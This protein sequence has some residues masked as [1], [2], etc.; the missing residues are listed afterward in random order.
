MGRIEKGIL[1]LV[2][3]TA[4]R[5]GP[6]RLPAGGEDS[7]HEGQSNPRDRCRRHKS[8]LGTWKDLERPTGPEPLEVKSHL[9]MQSV[10][11]Y[12]PSQDDHIGPAESFIA[13]IPSVV[14]GL[15]LAFSTPA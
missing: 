9:P 14:K 13:G 5:P 2:R 8:L 3:A 15:K 4:L 6:P 11:I 1:C 10:S 12:A 7:D